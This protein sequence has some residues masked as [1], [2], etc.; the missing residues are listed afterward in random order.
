[1]HDYYTLGFH[2]FA[3]HRTKTSMIS[4]SVFGVHPGSRKNNHI[5]NSKADVKAFAR[6]NLDVSTE[7]RV[8][9]CTES[10]LKLL[11]MLF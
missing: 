9:H 2:Q 4:D 1:M 3:S 11:A 7:E 8:K 10:F 5:I 6:S